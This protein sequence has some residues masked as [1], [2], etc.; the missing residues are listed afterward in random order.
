MRLLCWSAP[1]AGA[2]S[3]T[4]W[5]T[6]AMLRSP[7]PK[8]L[9]GIDGQGSAVEQHV[10]TTGWQ[11]FIFRA[12]VDLVSPRLRRPPVVAPQAPRGGRGRLRAVLDIHVGQIA[13]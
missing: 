5:R 2:G 7:V 9:H 11:Q 13:S 3:F 8:G 10:E 4:P 12:Q 6:V 1:D